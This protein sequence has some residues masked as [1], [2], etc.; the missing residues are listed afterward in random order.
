MPLVV[1]SGLGRGRGEG[2]WC[3]GGGTAQGGAQ[4]FA[5]DG[6]ASVLPTTGV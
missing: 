3:R 5:V 2:G 1:G 4:R 6:G